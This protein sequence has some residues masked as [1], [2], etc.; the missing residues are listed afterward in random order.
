MLWLI[1]VSVL[2]LGLITSLFWQYYTVSKMYSLDTVLCHFR[3]IQYDA[4]IAVIDKISGNANWSG[5]V[6]SEEL[7]KFITLVTNTLNNFDHLKKDVFRFKGFVEIFINIDKSYKRIERTELEAS[8]TTIELKKRYVNSLF[9][10]FKAIPFFRFRLLGFFFVT[11]VKFTA[12]FSVLQMFSLIR[13][14]AHMLQTYTLIKEQNSNR[15][16]CN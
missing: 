15:H 1:L 7:R 2:T 6:E 12:L 4:T 14:G 9:L 8:P 11:L 16:Y 13:K 10:A 5:N 3:Q